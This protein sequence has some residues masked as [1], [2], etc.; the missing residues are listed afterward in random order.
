MKTKQN[1]EKIRELNGNE[2]AD[3]LKDRKEELFNLRFQLATGHLE[4]HAQIREIRK[5]IARIHTVQRERELK[6][7]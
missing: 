5:E 6:L 2:L 7:R 3:R 1:L 4:N